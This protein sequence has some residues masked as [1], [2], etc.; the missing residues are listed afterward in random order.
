[1][2]W[3]VVDKGKLWSPVVVV[4]EW[5]EPDWECWSSFFP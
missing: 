5:K 4:I 1:M 2:A 3:N